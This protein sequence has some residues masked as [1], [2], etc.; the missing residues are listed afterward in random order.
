MY[1]LRINLIGCS[2]TIL[3]HVRREILNHEGEIDAEFPDAQSAVNRIWLDKDEARV[4]IIHLES[5]DDLAQLKLLSG[6]FVGRPIVALINSSEDPSL[7]FKS[8]RAGATQVVPLP[9]EAGDFQ[10]RSTRLPCTLEAGQAAPRS[11]RSPEPP[12][13]AALPRSP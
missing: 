3:P 10:E 2:E 11:S 5:V 7:V 12:A 6:S 9:L 8:M 13:V 1:P 4:F